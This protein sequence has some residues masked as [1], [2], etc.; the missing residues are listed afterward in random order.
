MVGKTH[1]SP[2]SFFNYLGTVFLSKNEKKKL[3]KE[4]F[5][6]RKGCFYLKVREMSLIER[7]FIR[8]YRSRE[9]I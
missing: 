6:N 4:I 8:L 2:V 7:K 1:I 5:T 9:K 3:S